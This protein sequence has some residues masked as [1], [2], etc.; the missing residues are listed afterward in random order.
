MLVPLVRGS[1]WPNTGS[2]NFG[3]DDGMVDWGVGALELRL[4]L[5][6]DRRMFLRPLE[7]GV[8]PTEVSFR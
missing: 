6:V 8:R 1:R 2:S 4:W 3:V 5:C 7:D